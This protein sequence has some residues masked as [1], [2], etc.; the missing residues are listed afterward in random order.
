MDDRLRNAAEEI[1]PPWDDVRHRRNW[2]AIQQGLRA[3]EGPAP[4]RRAGRWIALGAA[5]GL[6]AA[7]ALALVWL[8]PWQDGSPPP[9]ATPPTAAST[10]LVFR[11]GS[12][13][14]L[15]KQA[16]LEIAEESADVVRVIQRAGTVTYRVRRHRKAA[17]VV[18]TPAATVRVLG[19]VFTVIVKPSRDLIVRVTRGRVEV[20][21][22]RPEA[23]SPI[24]LT[25]G[26]SVQIQAPR[27]AP[28][29]P[30]DAPAR[31]EP[32]VVEPSRG[33]QPTAVAPRPHLPSPRARHGQPGARAVSPPPRRSRRPAGPPSAAALMQQVDQAR[34][35][36]RLAEAARLLRRLVALHPRD[37]WATIALF[38]LGQ[39]EAARGRHAQAARA[40]R[41][42]RSRSPHGPLAEDAL[43]AEARSLAASGQRRAA[44]RLAKRYLRLYPGGT[45]VL[46][47]KRLAP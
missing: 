37:P 8:R 13:A 36:G 22:H 12:Q 34:R 4:M 26:Q 19:T 42:C 23:A 20:V 18:S 44:Q 9:S 2:N 5:A 40:F 35:A 38:T 6:A 15:S 43:A 24:V 45:H 46:R 14:T 39:V 30:R 31:V 32:G 33:E 3:S 28:A 47:I 21:D 25:A 10:T 7:A 16:R 27:S 17:F 41:R 1:T 11:D 29:T